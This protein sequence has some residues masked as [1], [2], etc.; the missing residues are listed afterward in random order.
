MTVLIQHT[1]LQ[2]FQQWH[3]ST[4]VQLNAMELSYRHVMVV[5]YEEDEDKK[6]LGSPP[7][8][9]QATHIVS[10]QPKSVC[11]SSHA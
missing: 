6:I 11:S 10:G 3:A 9:K 7:T 1:A 5:L 4:N 8:G 2:T